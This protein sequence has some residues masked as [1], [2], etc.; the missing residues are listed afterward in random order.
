MWRRNPS[1][2]AQRHSHGAPF[3][4]DSRPAARRSPFRKRKTDRDGVCPRGR[5]LFEAAGCGGGGGGGGER[6]SSSEPS[7][8]STPPVLALT[9]SNVWRRTSVARGRRGA[10]TSITRG[11]EESPGPSLVPSLTPE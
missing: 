11:E 2:E 8:V 10:S 4:R 7:S 9:L 6:P 5:D 1:P 3:V